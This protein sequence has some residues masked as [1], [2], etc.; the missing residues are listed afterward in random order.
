[1]LK[2][3]CQNL[4]EPVVLGICPHVCVK[5]VQLVRRTPA[6]RIAQN[7]LVRIEHRK[8]LQKLFRFSQS[9]GLLEDDVAANGPCGRRNE[10]NDC[11]MRQADRIFEDAAPQD[12]RCNLLFTNETVVE[13][14]DQNIRINE[15]GQ[16]RTGP[17]F[18]NL[19][20]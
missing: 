7:S 12:L 18:S 9:V 1:M 16:A 17:L 5:P 6:D 11:L 13:P 15:S 2:I 10:L 3:F 4:V 8:L 20:R 19:G 14:V